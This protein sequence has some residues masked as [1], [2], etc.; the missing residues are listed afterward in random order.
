M[1]SEEDLAHGREERDLRSPAVELQEENEELWSL[2]AFVLG[3]LKMS[4]SEIRWGALDPN[5]A[6]EDPVDIMFSA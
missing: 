4:L 6:V 3:G 5:E 2:L 1:E